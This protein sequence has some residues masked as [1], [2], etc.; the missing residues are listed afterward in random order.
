MAASVRVSDDLFRVPPAEF[1]RARNREVE[2]LR[3]AGSTRA[4]R[5]VHTLKKPTPALWAANQVARE[6]RAAIG[7]LLTTVER[8]RRAQ[9]GG[10]ADVRE[11]TDAQ[12]AAL[13]E[14]TRAARARLEAAELRA[15]P[16]V[17]ARVSATLLGAAVDP[18]ARDD[19]RAGRLTAERAAPGF[20]IFASAPR[21]RLT[22]A[23]SSR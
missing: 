22:R 3:A 17:L 1:V 13:D 4:A 21:A 15:T 14:L 8:L 5:V 20:E 10:R 16:N 6:Q 2:R 23:R 9:L 11:A 19:L 18:D 7:R 12:R